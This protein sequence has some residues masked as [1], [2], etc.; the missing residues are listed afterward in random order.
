MFFN[1]E[2][3]E[4]EA[5][6]GEF[7]GV[8]IADEGDPL[9]AD[10]SEED[11]PS[12]ASMGLRIDLGTGRLLAWRLRLRLRLWLRLRMWRTVRLGQIRRWGL[13]KLIG[14]LAFLPTGGAL[15]VSG[16]TFS[17]A[18]PPLAFAVRH[19]LTAVAGGFGFRPIPRRR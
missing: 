18:P 15:S 5:A 3:G 4:A 19:C 17:L 10:F 6:P 8:L 16:L 13:V 12:F 1:E 14:G 2:F 11:L 7:A 9:F